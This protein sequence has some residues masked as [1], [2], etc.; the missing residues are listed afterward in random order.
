MAKRKNNT[1]EASEP[2]TR[3]IFILALGHPFYGRMAFNLAVSLKTIDP[4]IQIAVGINGDSLKELFRYDLYKYFDRIVTVPAEMTTRRGHTEY[5]R[6]KLAILDLTPWENTLYLDA[7]TIWLK[8]RTPSQLMDELAKV[9]LAIQNRGCQDLKKP[10]NNGAL[11]WT[12]ATEIRDAYGFKSGKLFSLYSECM[13]IKKTEE[14]RALFKQALECY[15]D[16]L[17]EHKEFAGGVP[18]E[19]PLAI[20]MVITGTYPHK[21]NWIPVYWEHLERRRLYDDQEKLKAEFFAFSIGGKVTPGP[22]KEYYNMVASAAF[23]LDGLKYPYFVINKK[24]FLP[25]R[26]KI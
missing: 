24:E 12:S 11:L 7:D 20:A 10:L 5:L 8:G 23:Q 21:E 2:T 13:W 3:G 17:V 9:P 4:E 18:D 16:L 15:D 19:L 14:N 6:A 25:E 22:V 1:P 26:K